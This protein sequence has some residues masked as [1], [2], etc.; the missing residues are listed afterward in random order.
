MTQTQLNRILALHKKFLKTGGIE[1]ERANFSATYLDKVYGRDDASN[2]VAIYE[3]GSSCTT[4]VGA[5]CSDEHLFRTSHFNSLDFK[6]ADLRGANFAGALFHNCDMSGVVF[7][8]QDLSSTWFLKVRIKVMLRLI[9]NLKGAKLVECDFSDC[10]IQNANFGKAEM[11]CC[12]FENSNIYFS[13][14]QSTVLK[15]SIFNKCVF[16]A[17]NIRNTDLS[18]SQ[19]ISANFKEST[20]A[21]SNISYCNFHNAI[22]SGLELV[23]LPFLSRLKN[24]KQLST[25]CI[26]CNIGTS[27]GGELIKHKVQEQAHIEEFAED[28]PNTYLLWLLTSDC[29]K[30]GYLLGGWATLLILLFS[31]L[32]WYLSPDHL[33]YPE[34]LQTMKESWFVHLYY[35][36]ATFTTL[37]YGD[38]SP[39][40][41][42]AMVLASI[43]VIIGFIF[44][45]LLITLFSNKITAK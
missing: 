28:R 4:L 10:M 45:G 44:L 29:G 43:E 11:H 35:S 22:I 36:V 42:L 18:N 40:T 31:V 2:K 26:G 13:S 3:N 27:I 37:G 19:F 32:F 21:Q 5:E 12:T 17:V 24:G 20:I 14:F 34:H 38:I 23:M 8:T 33:N 30:S 6:S 41:L 1:G 39:K 7:G 15:K 25:Q 16:W 9:A